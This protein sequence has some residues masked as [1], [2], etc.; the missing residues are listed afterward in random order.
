MRHS[1]PIANDRVLRATAVARDKLA[2]FLSNQVSDEG[3]VNGSCRSRVLESALTLQ[4]LRT[5]DLYPD[6]QQRIIGFLEHQQRSLSG[7]NALITAAV[8][9]APTALPIDGDF[10]GAGYPARK[11]LMLAT[12]LATLGATPF[13]PDERIDQVDYHGHASWT[14]VVLCAVKVLN[15]Y[16]TGRPHCV[17]SHDRAFLTH[18]I[19]CG[20]RRDVWEGHF[21]AHL[22]ALLALSRFQPDSPMIADGAAAILRHQR[23]DGGLPFILDMTTCLTALTGIGLHRAGAAPALLT[24]MAEQI[25][26]LQAPDGGWPYTHDVAQT[27]SDSASWALQFLRCSSPPRYRLAM[28]RSGQYY[29]SLHNVD[30]GYPTYRHGHE[31]ETAMTAGAV[32]ALAGHPPA[33]SLL[34]QATAYLI[35]S[36][37]PEGTFERSWSLSESFA[38][39]RVLDALHHVRPHSAQPDVERLRRAAH[40][41]LRKAQNRDAGWGHQ[42]DQPSDPISTAHAILALHR[43]GDTSTIGR[44][45]AYLLDQQLADGTYT[46]VPDQAAPR[47]LPYDLPQVANAFVLLALAT[48]TR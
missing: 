32:I 5:V 23:A 3:R 37:R 17:T 29:R 35:N 12:V 10:F 8:L 19:A 47:P 36:Q 33:A 6:R 21:P 7:I 1:A 4:L 2:Q 26:A 13:P 18:H 27:D 31:S 48:V 45:L 25:A 16:G 46:S 20:S 15:A 11:R 22:L 43:L 40:T 41:Y 39:Y 24:R 42:P 38:I 28:T 44:S 9:N 14:E 34:D 30:G